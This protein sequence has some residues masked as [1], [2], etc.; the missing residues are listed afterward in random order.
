VPEWLQIVATVVG[1][2][3]SGAFGAGIVYGVIR[4]R[5]E[6]LRSDLNRSLGD[7][8]DAHERIDELTETLIS[9]RGLSTGKF[10]ALLQAHAHTRHD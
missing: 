8:R 6:W 10:Q 4:T 2:V 7:A 3:V 9:E 1:A 5:L